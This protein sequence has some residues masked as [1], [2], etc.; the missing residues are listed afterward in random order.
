MY[1]V[2][3]RDIIVTFL[4]SFLDNQPT[5]CNVK[6]LKTLLRK[7]IGNRKRIFF[8][9]YFVKKHSQRPK[10]RTG[11]SFFERAIKKV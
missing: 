3:T 4:G 8:K 11:L 6:H 10:K 7:F 1:G 2:V 5:V 9:R